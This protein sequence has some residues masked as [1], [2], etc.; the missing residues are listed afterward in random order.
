MKNNKSI[1]NNKEELQAIRIK[2]KDK[3]KATENNFATDFN[4]LSSLLSMTRIYDN[5]KYEPIKKDVHTL[6]VQFISEYFK[7]FKPFGKENE[8][9]NQLLV[10]SITLGLSLLAVNLTRKR[11]KTEPSEG[12]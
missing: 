6:I 1:I 9:L 3:V 5:S 2:M 7:D 12:D 11:K 10:P 8:R 4:T